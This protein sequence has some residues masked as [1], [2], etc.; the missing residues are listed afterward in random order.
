[1]YEEAYIDKHS[2]NQEKEKATWAVYRFNQAIALRRAGNAV[3]FAGA[4]G[5]DGGMLLKTLDENGIPKAN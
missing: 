3:S 4:V 2:H 1:M 5:Q